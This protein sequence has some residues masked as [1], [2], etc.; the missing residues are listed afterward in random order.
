MKLIFRGS[1]T[2]KDGSKLFASSVGKKA[3]PIWIPE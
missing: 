3:F 1:I 2:L